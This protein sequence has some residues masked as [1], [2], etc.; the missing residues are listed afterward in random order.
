MNNQNENTQ[1]IIEANKSCQIIDKLNIEL[2]NKNLSANGS[3]SDDTA[4]GITSYI[5]INGATIET[6]SSE[7]RYI[8]GCF[9]NVNKEL[10]S[11]VQVNTNGTLTIPNN[12]YYF[13]SGIQ[14][15]SNKPTFKICKNGS[16]ALQ[17]TLDQDA[18]YN[19]D[20]EEIEGQQEIDDYKAAEENVLD[21][22]DFSAAEDLD[23]TINAS[24]S[25]FIWQIVERLRQISSKIVLLFTSILG[26]GLIKMILNR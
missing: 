22:L 3:I 17:D 11:C 9:Y 24:T 16:Q 7:N 25:S 19:T 14:K 26:L 13:R 10:I 5:N 18:E 2:D 6:L 21:S 23:I 1:A 4:K 8:Y 15:S 20:G 12:A